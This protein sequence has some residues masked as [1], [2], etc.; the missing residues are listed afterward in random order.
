MMVDLTIIGYTGCNCKLIFVEKVIIILFPLLMYYC[1]C[2]YKPSIS[3]YIS[4]QNSI[5]FT[6]ATCI[7]MY[8]LIQPINFYG[9]NN[10]KFLIKN[11][12]KIF[13][14]NKG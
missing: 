6:Y 5:M 9:V 13:S 8:Y 3:K 7:T 10:I 4:Y 2:S 1:L 14:L 12:Q 11:L